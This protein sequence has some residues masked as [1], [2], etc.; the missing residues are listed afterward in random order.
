MPTDDQQA[1]ASIAHTKIF[2]SI[3]TGG[4]GHYAPM[5]AMLKRIVAGSPEL[6]TEEAAVMAKMALSALSGLRD[7]LFQT[8]TGFPQ[9]T[10][11]DPTA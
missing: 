4:T 2:F 5:E 11:S 9:S 1:C 10:V 7:S 8:K 3:E 6:Y